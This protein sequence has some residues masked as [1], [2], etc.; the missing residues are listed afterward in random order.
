MSG[1]WTQPRTLD[2]FEP[3]K[4][5]EATLLA[6]CDSGLVVVIGDGTR[7]PEDAPEA[8][9][10]RAS[11]LRWLILGAEGAARGPHE[12]GVRVQGAFIESDGPEGDGTRGLNLAGCAVAWDIALFSCQFENGPWFFG[13]RLAGLYLDESWV[14][15]LVA[16]RLETRRGLHLRNGFESD[17][18]VR[19]LGARIGGNLDCFGAKLRNEGGFALVADGL[20]TIGGVFLRDGF[21][22]DGAIRLHGAQIGADLDCG[23]AKLLNSGGKT[24]HADRLTTTGGVFLTNGLESDGEIRLPG[25][26]ISGNLDCNGAKMSNARTNALTAAGARIAG[27]LF[28]RG[29]PSVIGAIDLANA[30]IGDFNDDPACWPKAQGEVVLDRCVYGGFTGGGV[31]PAT[32]IDWLDRQDPARFGKT[33]WPQPWEQC[34]KVL[35]EMGHPED[36]RAVLIAKEARQRAARRARMARGPGR[37]LRGAWDWVLGKTVRYGRQPTLAFVWLLGLWM[38]GTGV[39]WGA[40][41]VDAV[42]PNN[43]FVLRSPEWVLCGVEAPR[44]EFAPSLQKIATGRALPGESRRDC[45]ERQPEAQQYPR[46]A[47]LLYSLDTLLPVVEMEMQDFWIPDES[48]SRPWGAAARVYLW[49]HIALGWA[50]SLLAVA[51]FSGI[52]KSD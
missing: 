23:G 8:V 48:A 22:S 29:G 51:G 40:S 18:A 20:T 13:A 30:E 12:T 1:G 5:A 3:L 47:A 44:R 17:G 42:K 41:A 10:I 33:F 25:A 9:R 14:P 24:L 2:R 34:A 52:V 15:G 11:F 36:A 46:F 45:D 43:A 31:D 39:F 16:D 19:L 49:V 38:L 4:P 50:L 21:E 6:E 37:A 32:R 35:R 27:T 26:R 28:L 7:P